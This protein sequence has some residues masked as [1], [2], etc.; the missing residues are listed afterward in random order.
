MHIQ[1][2]LVLTILG[3]SLSAA[4][5][6]RTITEAYEV[7]LSD[8][9]LPRSENGNLTFKQCPDCEAETF[10]ATAAT[11]YL[12]NDRDFT[13]VEFKKQLKRVTNRTDH[14]VAVL[15]HLESNT[16][17]AIKVWLRSTRETG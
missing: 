2:L 9:R 3:L 12:I 7:D 10:R 1:R 16:I 15:H 6:F 5:E 4:A 11:R 8:L 17:Q 14:S 13:L